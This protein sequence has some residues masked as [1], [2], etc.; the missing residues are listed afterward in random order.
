MFLALW[1]NQTKYN[2]INYDFH[3]EIPIKGWPWVKFGIFQISIS[4]TPL[5]IHIFVKICQKWSGT[6]LDTFWNIKNT[7]HQK[8]IFP[9][10]VAPQNPFFSHFREFWSFKTGWLMECVLGGPKWNQG[11]WKSKFD[12]FLL[13]LGHQKGD[14]R[15]NFKICQN[16]TSMNLL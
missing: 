15:Q 5:D 14:W 13:K 4:S 9:S 2:Q 6:Y 8:S 11:V 10:Y 7:F 3:I 1:P 16:A 12:N